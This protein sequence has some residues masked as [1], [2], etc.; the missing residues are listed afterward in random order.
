M[1]AKA[2]GVGAVVGLTV[3]LTAALGAA[4]AAGAA[5]AGQGP[6]VAQGDGWLAKSGRFA[7]PTA[8]IPSDAVTY[9][10]KLVPA[11]AEIG[12]VERAAGERTAVLL[13]V[14][15]LKA[16]REYGAHIHT[17][18]CGADGDA[19]GPHYQDKADPVTPS[20]DPAYANDENEAWLDFKTDGSG[21]GWSFVKQD[22]RVRKGEARSVVLHSEHTHTGHGDAGTA[23][24]RLA[25]FTVPF[26]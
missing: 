4:P 5:E 21:R 20:V 9:D 7:P 17:K 22:W 26:A 18:P 23:G 1:M 15:G 10:Q 11:G 13:A 8:L 25:C 14:R 12:V 19:A 6:R 2:K 24:D 3:G 16:D